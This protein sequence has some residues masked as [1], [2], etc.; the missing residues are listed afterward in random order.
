MM[1]RIA[2]LVCLLCWP[3]WLC[4]GIV[5]MIGILKREG[6]DHKDTLLGLGLGAAA[7]ASLLALSYLVP[8]G[9][10]VGPF[11]LT[12]GLEQDPF[13]PW[14]GMSGRALMRLTAFC[15][16]EHE[17]LAVVVMRSLYL[18]CPLVAASLS[19]QIFGKG[20]SSGSSL[21][22]TSIL[23]MVVLM[24]ASPMVFIGLVNARYFG[25]V[26]VVLGMML[27]SLHEDVERP[28]LAPALSLFASFP[29][30][31]FS[32]PESTGPVLL[33]I[34]AIGIRLALTRG[35]KKPCGH[36]FH[37]FHVRMAALAALCVLLAFAVPGQTRYLVSELR[38]DSIVLGKDLIHEKHWVNLALVLLK[39]LALGIP[40]ALLAQVVLTCGAFVPACFRI[41]ALLI[42]RQGNLAEWIASLWLFCYLLIPS[43]HKEGLA[44]FGGG[45][46]YS[47]LSIMSVWYL[48]ARWLAQAAPRMR[49]VGLWIIAAATALFVSGTL[50][51]Y[52]YKRKE[53]ARITS[54]HWSIT[55]QVVRIACRKGAKGRM[56]RIMVKK[57]GRFGD[58]MEPRFL[59]TVYGLLGRGGCEV[60]GQVFGREKEHA[61]ASALRRPND[62]CLP[63]AAGATDS[64]R[65][66]GSLPDLAFIVMGGSSEHAAMRRFL[67]GPDNCG[68]AVRRSWPKAV[69]LFRPRPAGRAGNRE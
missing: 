17:R 64:N 9:T 34:L 4:S 12:D 32:R 14:K 18:L 13:V 27:V 66:A 48:A 30:L 23:P 53:T 36:G 28:A 3:L 50:G 65:P 46:K 35:E 38:Y 7:A 43:I 55:P 31:A 58:P 47:L 42:R 62:L 59:T 45:P 10:S 67:L 33:A 54:L 69:L 68:W 15:W 22:R 19:R 1:A 51:F 61:D 8:F 39:R 5:M 21:S 44:S 24:V 41:R 63:V 6:K 16:S 29:L 56:P 40:L 20:S 60:T 2:E 26:P 57:M 52:V 37:G 25:F 11:Y 49:A